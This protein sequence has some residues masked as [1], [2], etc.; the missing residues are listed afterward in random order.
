VQFGPASVVASRCQNEK[1]VENSPQL[2]PKVLTS[3]VRDLNRASPGKGREGFKAMNLE[4]ITD[5]HRAVELPLSDGTTVRVTHHAAQTLAEVYGITK[6]RIKK[7]KDGF[8]YV[9]ATLS[10][11][12]FVPY[13]VTEDPQ[14]EVALRDLLAF[15]VYHNGP[16]FHFIPV[17]RGSLWNGRVEMA[18]G[19]QRNLLPDNF[20]LEWFETPY[21]DAR[22]APGAHKP[23]EE[24]AA[25]ADSNEV[26]TITID[27]SLSAPQNAELIQ[28]QRGLLARYFSLI[29]NEC[30]K[31]LLRSEYQADEVAQE[32]TFQLLRQIDN[33]MCPA[34]NEVN[35]QKWAK[36]SA[37]LASLRKLRAIRAG[38][39]VDVDHDKAEI[40]LLRAVRFLGEQ[41]EKVGSPLEGVSMRDALNL[42]ALAAELEKA[43]KEEAETI[44]AEGG[45]WNWNR[46][47]LERGLEFS[48]CNAT[49]LR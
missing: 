22:L 18:D 49:P 37:W 38:V 2:T 8:E 20:R 40:R 23:E 34:T 17:K 44:K 42:P 28:E 24:R 41:S 26:E 36:G 6:G 14:R 7:A 35:F 46:V 12:A 47:D 45:A 21:A 5:I 43:S 48:V 10:R 9:V 30:K 16:A 39:C 25:A 27:E 3:S 4:E 13:A 33:G 32:T 31:I 29:Q 15:Y 1:I 11:K 19:D